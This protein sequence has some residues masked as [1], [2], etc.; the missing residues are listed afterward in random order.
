MI[1]RKDGRT[2]SGSTAEDEETME[3]SAEAQMK[4]I[5]ETGIL[6]RI[7][8]RRFADAPS[9]SSLSSRPPPLVQF[10]T[11][12]RAAFADT[13]KTPTAADYHIDNEDDDDLETVRNLP[14]H[15]T[16]ADQIDTLPLWA[17]R[18]FDTFLWSIPFMTVFVCLDVAIH[19]QYGQPLKVW[20]ELSRMGNVYPSALF[21]IHYTLHYHEQVLANL[22]LFGLSTIGGSY[23][24]YIMNR[25]SYLLVMRRVPPLGALWIYAVVRMHLSHAVLSLLLVALWAWVMNLSIYV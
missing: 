12:D 5:H 17:D 1:G 7:P 24:V 3:L 13:L 4:I 22:L 8:R 23:M 2:L 21:L 25:L 19:A 15:P 20:S 6:E 18:A 9:S 11:L 16:P 10:S 14:N